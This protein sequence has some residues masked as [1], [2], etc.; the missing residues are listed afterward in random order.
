MINY[1]QRKN[2]PDL[3]YIKTDG[4]TSRPTVVF[5]GGF[6]S[7]M[8]GSKATYLEEQ[9]RTWGQS[10][11]RFDYR[12]HGQSGGKFEEACISEWTEDAADILKS[13]TS[14]KV[15]L[16]GSSMGG[17]IAFL[18]ALKYPEHVQAIVGLAAA[19]DFTMWMEAAMS[20]G[21]KAQLKENGQF[22]LPNDYDGTPYII[23]KKLIEDGRNNTLLGKSITID[24]SVRLIQGK[25][26]ADVPWQT[27]EDIKRAIQ[28]NDVKITYIEEADHRLSNL[29]QLEIIGRVVQEI[30]AT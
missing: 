27:A 25:K 21:Q 9:C 2:A 6:K 15:I 30:C 16:V 8:M 4:D 23:T 20:E 7:D 17:W 3:A 14:R 24:V 28:G 26:D 12:G 19:P 22:D 1:L 13:C 10:Y 11:L 29:D 18:L 5:L